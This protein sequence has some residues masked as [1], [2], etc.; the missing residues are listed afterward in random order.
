MSQKKLPAFQLY[1]GDWLKD[2]ALS[3]CSAMTRGIW[4]DMICRMHEFDRCGQLI[5]TIGELSQLCRCSHDELLAGLVQLAR[6]RTADVFCAENDTEMRA[7]CAPDVSEM[8]GSFLPVSS[9]CPG[10]FQIVCRRMQVAYRERL[11][12]AEKKAKRRKSGSVP[13]KVPPAVPQ[14]SLPPSS[15]SSSASTIVN[16]S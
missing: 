9:I 11:K 16:I 13:P 7:K 12:D 5:G 14:K 8:R 2:P 4:I 6:T 1:T 15:V 10:E 3:M